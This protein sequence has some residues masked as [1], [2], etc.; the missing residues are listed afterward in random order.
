MMARFPTNCINCK[1]NLFASQTTRTAAQG[2]QT[3]CAWGVRPLPRTPRKHTFEYRTLF[4]DEGTIAGRRFHDRHLT[5]HACVSFPTIDRGSSEEH[6]EGA[7]SSLPESRPDTTHSESKVSS[8][9]CSINRCLVIPQHVVTT[10][11]NLIELERPTQHPVRGR[12]PNVRFFEPRNAMPSSC[13]CCPYMSAHV[14]LHLVPTQALMRF[15]LVPDEEKIRGFRRVQPKAT[16]APV[17]LKKQSDRR[18]KH[19]YMTRRAVCP[20]TPALQNA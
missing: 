3:G 13:D 9:L 7:I 19:S 14:R 4:Q 2:C 10:G 18:L 20:T 5:V 17:P 8:P 11:C 12:R 16:G 15:S 6:G 1:G